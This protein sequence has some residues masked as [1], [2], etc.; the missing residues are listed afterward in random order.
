MRLALSGL[1]TDEQKAQFPQMGCC[2]KMDG[3]KKQGACCKMKK[4]MKMEHG[5]CQKAE[6]E[7]KE[8]KK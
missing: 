1:L 8:E 5:K 4:E 2:G 7:K 6:E 3:E